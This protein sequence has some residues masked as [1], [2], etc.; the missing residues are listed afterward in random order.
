MSICM[1][2]EEE[3]SELIEIEVTNDNGEVVPA[4]ING[5]MY[6]SICLCPDCML[7]MF[8]KGDDE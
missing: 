3:S 8:S 4:K 7:A 2:C 5:K 1:L 6:E